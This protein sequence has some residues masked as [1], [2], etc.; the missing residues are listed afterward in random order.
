MFTGTRK[1]EL[2]NGIKYVLK[3]NEGKKKIGQYESILT[4]TTTIHAKMTQEKPTPYWL[5]CC[6]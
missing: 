3:H 2:K 5:I 4:L 1:V 6:N